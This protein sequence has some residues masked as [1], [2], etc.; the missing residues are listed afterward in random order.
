[1]VETSYIAFLLKH[2]RVETPYIA[3]PISL[4]RLSGLNLPPARLIPPPIR[5]LKKAK[6]AIASFARELFNSC[7]YASGLP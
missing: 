4:S 3:S 5:G 1:M 6:P 7:N 2:L